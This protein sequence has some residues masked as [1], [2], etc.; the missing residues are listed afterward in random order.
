[1]KIIQENTLET[2]LN[3]VNKL[4]ELVKPTYGPAS[5]KVIIGKGLYA[6]VLDDGVQI[7]KDLELEDEAENYVLKLI[8]EVAIKTNDR[9]GDGTTSSIILLQAILSEAVKSK[10]TPREIV[11]NLDKGLK[12]AV[13]TIR[14]QSKSIKAKEDLEKVARISFDNEEISQLLSDIIFEIGEEGLID[15]Q[16][17]QGATVESEVVAGFKVDNGFVSPYMITEG[18]KCVIEDAT[19]LVTDGSFHMNQELVPVLERVVAKGKNNLVIFCKEFTGEALS[20]AIVNKLKGGFR[21][22]AIQTTG[23]KLDDI[24]VFT[25]ARHV[26]LNTKIEDTDFGFAKKVV[27]RIEDTVII[28]GS[29]DTKAYVEDLKAQGGNES[30]VA[31]LTNAVAVIKVGAK[32]E[33]EAKAL[34][35]KVEDASN[36]IKVAYKGGVVSGAGTTLAKL[37]TSSDI[38]NKAMK[39]PNKQLKVN[40]GDFEVTDNIIDPAEVVIA[41]I[42]SAVSIAKLLITTTGIIYETNDKKLHGCI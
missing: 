30:R 27:S 38:L 40:M 7:A 1:M 41:G 11:D 23:A 25:G 22:L 2:I 13:K 33:S 28:D 31:N 36:A 37:K 9:V 35:F 32:T 12:E 42:E 5:N 39:Y 4:A 24:A 15:V 17:S 10:L 21:C 20:T 14:E 16:A 29:G 26:L 8:K 18:D 19:I 3:A 34:Q 6:S